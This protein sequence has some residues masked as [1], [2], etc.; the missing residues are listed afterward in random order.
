MKSNRKIL[1]LLATL[2]GMN[3][4]SQSDIEIKD[5]YFGG[6]L[7]VA[8]ALYENTYGP[9]LFYSFGI[10]KLEISAGTQLYNDY[11]KKW[12]PFPFEKLDINLSY[13]VFPW[14]NKFRYNLYFQTV[15]AINIYFPPFYYPETKSITH[16]NLYLGTG[17]EISLSKRCILSFDLSA[18]PRLRHLTYLTTA[19]NNNELYADVYGR[20]SFGYKFVK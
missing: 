5:K 18:G 3:L 20:I 9:T 6:G 1:F 4:Y 14:T 15:G 19:P 12:F 10:H 13:K 7:N 11:K 17:V 2:T 8:I 16:Y